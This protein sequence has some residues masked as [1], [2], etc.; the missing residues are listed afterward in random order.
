MQ[1]AWCSTAGAG[2]GC[3][4]PP[5]PTPESSSP[6]GPPPGRRTY[7]TC[8]PILAELRRPPPR[9]TT[10]RPY[11]RRYTPAARRH[12]EAA[13][14]DH[15]APAAAAD[16]ARQAYDGARRELAE[17]HWWHNAPTV[18]RPKARP[19]PAADRG[20]AQR[21]RHPPRVHRHPGTHRD[22]RGRAGP[23]RPTIRPAPAGERRLSR[24]TRRRPQGRPADLAAGDRDRPGRAPPSSRGPPT[25]LPGAQSGP[26]HLAP[27]GR[28]PGAVQRRALSSL[29]ASVDA[30]AQFGGEVPRAHEAR[31]HADRP[32]VHRDLQFGGVNGGG[33][34]RTGRAHTAPTRRPQKGR[35]PSTSAARGKRYLRWS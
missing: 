9:S 11:G 19:C 34:A 3:G 10:R 30:V 2:S 8:P 5:W 27:N 22:S 24:P 17:A 14:P 1:P 21:R 20:R 25:A 6:P 31:H 32:P 16:T 29:G 28:A 13:H 33:P 15:P 23:A 7:R 26:G 35:P 12:A 4:G 18:P